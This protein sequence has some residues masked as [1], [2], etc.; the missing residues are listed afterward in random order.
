[1]KYAAL[2]LNAVAVA[3]LG[4]GLVGVYGLL[5]HRALPERVGQVELKPLPDRTMGNRQQIAATLE[6][7]EQVNQRLHSTPAASGRPLVAVPAPGMPGAGGPSMPPR[8]VTVLLQSNGEHVAVVDDRLVRQGGRL[9]GGG[10]VVKVG[11]DQVQV[12]ESNG[13]QTL[14]VP[15]ERL[16][17]GTL[18]SA[19]A[20]DTTQARQQFDA[21]RPLVAGEPR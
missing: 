19:A 2:A 1:M 8:S 13:R 12:R 18:R 6:A 7:I 15:V 10:R 20:P 5:S 4:W 14:S 17:V 3:L 9:S 11:R 16:R 21:P